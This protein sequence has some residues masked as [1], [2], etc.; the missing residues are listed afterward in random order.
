MSGSQIEI[1]GGFLNCSH[2]CDN[3]V[4]GEDT[5]DVG[6]SSYDVLFVVTVASV[7]LHYAYCARCCY[8]WC[9]LERYDAWQNDYNYFVFLLHCCKIHPDHCLIGMSAGCFWFVPYD[10]L[11]G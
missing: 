8:C 11:M 1:K 2:G 7:L 9:C 3:H 6:S 5:D 10:C 4:D